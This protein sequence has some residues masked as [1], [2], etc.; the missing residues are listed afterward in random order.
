MVTSWIG[1][2][3]SRVFP[4]EKMNAPTFRQR[5][6]TSVAE[7]GVAFPFPLPPEL[8]DNQISVEAAKL[9]EA[10]TLEVKRKISDGTFDYKSATPLEKAIADQIQFDIIEFANKALAQKGKAQELFLAKD[11]D[12]A[13]RATV[14]KEIDLGILTRRV[15]FFLTTEKWDGNFDGVNLKV[16]RY[17]FVYEVGDKKVVSNLMKIK[18]PM[19]G[20]ADSKKF[21]VRSIGR[22]M[23][24]NEVVVTIDLVQNIIPLL[25]VTGAVGSLLLGGTGY[26]LTK[27]QK[28]LSAPLLW[29]VVIAFFLLVVF[30][31]VRLS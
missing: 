13:R 29:V 12:R 30:G 4:N 27:A 24:D 6:A 11:I 14:N 26:V 20:K 15:P 1:I 23:K 5:V 8:G 22:G 25:I 28:I 31:K 2:T 18:L 19:E 17:D 9:K 16:G 21:V 10:V 3:C 7:T